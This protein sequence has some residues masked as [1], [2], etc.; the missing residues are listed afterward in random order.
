MLFWL[1]L[2]GSIQAQNL[3]SSPYSR[4]GLGEIN[5]QSFATSQ[6]MGGSFIAW[7]QD[8]LAPF[9]INTANP[10]SLAG[11]RLSAFELGG[12][13]QLNRHWMVRAE[14]GFLASR[15]QFIGGLQYRFG[16]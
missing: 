1:C 5:N 15:Q 14:Y 2:S 11:I 16:L 9:F 3:T 12:Q 8:T 6:A 7:H 10:A 4:Y 13:F